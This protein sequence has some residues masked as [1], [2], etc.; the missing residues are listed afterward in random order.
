MPF[1]AVCA[2]YSLAKKGIESREEKSNAG[3]ER[4][5]RIHIGRVVEQLPPGRGVESAPTEN[6]IGQREQQSNLVVGGD[7]AI[8]VYPVHGNGHDE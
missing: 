3:G 5:E 8:Y 2:P 7:G 1:N 6:Q 4:Y